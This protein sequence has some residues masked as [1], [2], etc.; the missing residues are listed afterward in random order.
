[1][2][3]G[4]GTTEGNPEKVCPWTKNK[5]EIVSCWCRQ[6][7]TSVKGLHIH[8][9]RRNVWTTGPVPE[10]KF[11]NAVEQSNL[12]HVRQQRRVARKKATVL[13]DSML[14]IL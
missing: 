4:G 7:F 13:L 10:Q 2:D 14:N 12:N 5:V 3:H 8:Q 11:S 9:A 6:A 1:M